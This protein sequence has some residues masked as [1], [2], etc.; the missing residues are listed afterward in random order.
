LA[1]PYK[2]NTD[3]VISNQQRRVEGVGLERNLI[4]FAKRR[5]HEL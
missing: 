5:L 1:N 4:Q 3:Y 2:F